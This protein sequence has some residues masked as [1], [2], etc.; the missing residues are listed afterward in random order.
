[1]RFTQLLRL[2]DS[3]SSGCTILELV[4]GSQS[5]ASLICHLLLIEVAAHSVFHEPFTKQTY[6]LWRVYSKSDDSLLCSA[7]PY[8]LSAQGHH[9]PGASAKVNVF[10]DAH[11]KS[12][13]VCAK[14][15]YFYF[16]K[17]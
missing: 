13:F 10:F 9:V 11:K 6:K 4:D 8:G 1:M 16:K 7:P 3:R 5:Y 12:L 14:C 2:S 15:Q 17:G